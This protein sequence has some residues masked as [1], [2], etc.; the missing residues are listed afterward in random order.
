MNGEAIDYITE[1][2][3]EGQEVAT[4][5]YRSG[6]ETIFSMPTISEGF[7]NETGMRTVI[8][9]VPGRHITY[10]PPKPEPTGITMMRAGKRLEH[11]LFPELETR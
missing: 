5:S 8:V 4:R 10:D 9:G 7:N 2:T 11:I 6:L 3:L 1:E